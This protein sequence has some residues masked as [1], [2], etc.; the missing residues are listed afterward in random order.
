MTP[1]EG[2]S[3]EKIIKLANDEEAIKLY[4]SL[5]E[6]LR[7]AEEKFQVK[8]FARNRRLSITGEEQNVLA[9]F[10][11]FSG[12]VARVRGGGRA[13]AGKEEPSQPGNSFFHKGKIIRAKT[14]GQEEY[15]QKVRKD[16]IVFSIGPAGTGKTYLAVAF[17][18]DFLKHKRVSRIILTRPAVEA[19]ESLGFLPGDF[20]AK[21]NPYLRP[22]YD[23]LYDMMD[24]EEVARYMQRGTIEVAPLNYMRGRTLN[25]AFVILDEGQNTTHD[26]MK[27]FLTRLGVA[28]KAVITGDITQVDLPK[29]KLSGLK[30]CQKV[31]KGI[32]GISFAYLTESD[33]VRHRLVKDIVNAY[34]KH[35]ERT[36]K[37]YSV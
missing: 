12:E 34:E 36:S 35:A 33:V 4:G 27:M 22:L 1:G 18:I 9:A 16:D 6:N 25:D 13:E 21:I 17:A 29:G 30:E 23:A 2:T 32:E 31:L 19:G 28:S 14:P 3:L 26:Q 24:A 8:V 7:F 5:D 37:A 11:F 20:Y 15:I 10:E